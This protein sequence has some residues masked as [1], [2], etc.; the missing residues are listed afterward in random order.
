MLVI[1]IVWYFFK[2]NFSNLAGI[3]LIAVRVRVG[4]YLYFL[5]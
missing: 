4:F 1:G 5:L 2:L 3:I